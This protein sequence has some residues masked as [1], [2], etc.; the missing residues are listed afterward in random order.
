MIAFRLVF[1]SWKAWT[2]SWPSKAGESNRVMPRTCL[3]LQNLC[4]HLVAL[5]NNRKREGR[6]SSPQTDR[7]THALA[8]AGAR[9]SAVTRREG[10]TRI[11]GE[12]LDVAP[13]PLVLP[14]AHHV[15]PVVGIVGASIRGL[16]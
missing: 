11:A 6:G 10:R 16:E 14:V 9:N 4:A 13:H 15:L 1:S 3:L 8:T 2:P 7:R 5:R 12:G